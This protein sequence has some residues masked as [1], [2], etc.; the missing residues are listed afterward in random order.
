MTQMKSQTSEIGSSIY[1]LA[2]LYIDLVTGDDTRCSTVGWFKKFEEAE[3]C[4]LFN[5]G[6]IQ[7]AGWYN[8]AV[9]EKINEGLYGYTRLEFWYYMSGKDIYAI[10]KPEQLQGTIG[11]AMS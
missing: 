10:S 5:W 2:T 11:W 4:I 1:M 3:K 8:H 6:D 7:E 9:I